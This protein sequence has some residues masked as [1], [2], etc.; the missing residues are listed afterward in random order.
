MSCGY[1][2]VPAVNLLIIHELSELQIVDASRSE[3]RGLGRQTLRL[4]YYTQV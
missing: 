1:L 3:N 2:P 4:R